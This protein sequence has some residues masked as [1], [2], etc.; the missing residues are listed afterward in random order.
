[1]KFRLF[2]NQFHRL[3]YEVEADS[4]EEAVQ[5]WIQSRGEGFEFK[6]DEQC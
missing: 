3:K 1:M 2:E 6:D 4:E 5:R